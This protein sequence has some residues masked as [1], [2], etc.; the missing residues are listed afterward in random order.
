MNEWLEAAAGKLGGG[1]VAV[2]GDEQR[3]LLELARVAAHASGDRRNAPLVAYLVGLAR[4]RGDSRSVDEIVAE[5]VSALS[6]E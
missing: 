1:D 3:A 4:G 5:I 2:S 6:D